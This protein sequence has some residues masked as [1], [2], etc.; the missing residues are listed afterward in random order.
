MMLNLNQIHWYLM[1]PKKYIQ[2]VIWIQVVFL[3]CV[4]NLEGKENIEKFTIPTKEG[5]VFTLT[6]DC[7]SKSKLMVFV[8]GSP[9]NGSDFLPYLQDKDFQTHFC[10]MSPDRLGFGFSK[11]EEFIPSVNTQGKGISEMIQSFIVSQK[12]SVTSIFIVGHSYGGPVSMK[13]FLLL[14]ESLKKNGKVF[15][16]SAPMDPMYEELR[17]YNHLAKSIIIEWILPKSWVRSNEEMFQLKQDLLGLELELRQFRFP[18][19]MIHGDSDG[20]VPWE[21]TNY[22][23]HESYKGESK[24]YLLS[25]GSHFIPW[26]RFSEIK[27]IVFKEVSL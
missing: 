7:Q 11:R 13:S 3:Q 12:L 27:S 8:H 19:V 5:N 4:P 2:M 26:T 18:V 14:S 25:G 9:G 17:F 1:D 6:N 24:V 21:H 16:L 23:N 20:L 10:M 15:L 22:L